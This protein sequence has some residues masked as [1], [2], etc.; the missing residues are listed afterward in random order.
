MFCFLKPQKCPEIS[1]F[2]LIFLFSVNLFLA[3][4]FYTNSILYFSFY[5][6]KNDLPVFYVFLETDRMADL[7]GGDVFGD[8]N[9]V[10]PAASSTESSDVFASAVS[11]QE[12]ASAPVPVPVPGKPFKT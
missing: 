6:K 10:Q 3:C 7:L 4:A 8:P 11:T 2:F 12:P 1:S 5:K 9:K